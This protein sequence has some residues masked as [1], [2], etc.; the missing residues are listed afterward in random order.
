MA[1]KNKFPFSVFGHRSG[2]KA[3]IKL[4][5]FKYEDEAEAAAGAIKLLTD[6][7]GCRQYDEVFVSKMEDG[8]N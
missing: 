8:D 5:K 3:A 6:R 4:A 2:E 7:V 1:K